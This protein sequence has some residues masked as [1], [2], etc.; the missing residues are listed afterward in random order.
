MELDPESL[1]AHV[2]M[3]VASGMTLRLP[4]GE[5]DSDES[6]QPRDMGLACC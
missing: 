1:E 3:S 6:G 4:R 5:L 2:C